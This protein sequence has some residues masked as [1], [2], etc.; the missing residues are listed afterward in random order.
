MSR[1]KQPEPDLVL[2]GNLWR[3]FA[4]GEALNAPTEITLTR[5]QFDAALARY[6]PIAEALS[7]MGYTAD[8]AWAYTQAEA[9]WAVGLV[10]V[11]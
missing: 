1:P 4:F 6:V 7:E 5:E 3:H 9:P 10:G 8:Q 2:V 11:A